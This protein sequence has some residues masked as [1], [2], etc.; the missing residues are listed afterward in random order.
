MDFAHVDRSQPEGPTAGS[1]EARASLALKAIAGLGLAGVVLALFP[2]LVPEATLLVVAFNGGA[3][4]MAVIYIVVA[5]ALDRRRAWAN[6]S[7]RPLLVLIAGAGLYIVVAA[8]ASGK[9]RIPFDIALAIWAW[10]G[11]PDRRPIPD[12]QPRGAWMLGGITA[13][14]I[15][16]LAAR[17]LFGWGGLLDV[18]ARDLKASISVDCGAAGSDLPR[19]ITVTYDWSWTA[20]SPLPSGTDEVVV[21][22]TGD[23]A[24]GHPLYLFDR[25]PEP[26]TGIHPGRDVYPSAALADQVVSESRGSW[27]WGIALDEQQLAASHFELRLARAREAPAGPEPLKITAAYI[28]LGVWRSD[29]PSVTC[30]W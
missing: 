9:I 10:R 19:T 20:T 15:V 8:F 25:A 12:R 6:A 30:S 22:W 16:T 24:D 13:A 14:L 29:S 2:G 28:H 3:L 4:A 27:I 7:L 21:G 1:L 26:A 17:P 11:A 23:D 18:R 5:V